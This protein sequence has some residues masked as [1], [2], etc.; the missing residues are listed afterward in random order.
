MRQRI[1]QSPAVHR[2]GDALHP[3]G[4]AGQRL[5]EKLREQQHF[6]SAGAQQRSEGIVLL[7]SSG[8]PGQ[9]VEQQSVIVARG[10]SLE[11]GSGPVQDY[12]SQPADLGVDTQVGRGHQ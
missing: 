6:H 10:Q 8:H 11:L 5:G 2:G 7:L 12:S 3:R 9:A 1:T 4:P